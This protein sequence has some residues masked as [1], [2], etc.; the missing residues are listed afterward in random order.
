MGIF[1]HARLPLFSLIFTCTVLLGLQI[2]IVHVLFR[3]M[4]FAQSEILYKRLP[5][6]NLIFLC[7]VLLLCKQPL[8][9]S[10]ACMWS[11]N[12]CS[13][14]HTEYYARGFPIVQFDLQIQKDRF[15]KEHIVWYTCGSKSAHSSVYKCHQSC[16]SNCSGCANTDPSCAHSHGR[17]LQHAH[18]SLMVKMV[19]SLQLVHW[20]L[21]ESCTPR[22]GCIGRRIKQMMM[23]STLR[24]HYGGQAN[25]NFQR[26][27]WYRPPSCWHR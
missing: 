17:F 11:F 20:V 3:L 5:L 4:L 9:H 7:T 14:M 6:F 15:S 12:W 24:D 8:Y 18:R 26:H 19:K 1:M 13:L 27:R 25:L 10:C 22:Q 23:I 16:C 2:V 21:F